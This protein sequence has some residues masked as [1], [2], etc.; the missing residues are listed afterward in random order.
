MYGDVF[1]GGTRSRH[2]EIRLQPKDPKFKLSYEQIVGLLA[3]AGHSVKAVVEPGDPRSKSGKFKTYITT[4]GFSV[5]FAGGGNAGQTRENTLVG[6]LL[7]LIEG[8]TPSPHLLDLLDKLG[9]EPSNVVSADLASAKRVK[10]PLALNPS[11]VGEIISD[12]TIGLL[13]GSRVFISLKVDTGGG[14]SLSNVG[15]TGAF[16]LN[17]SSGTVTQAKHQYDSLLAAVGLSKQKIAKGLQSIVRGDPMKDVV[18]DAPRFDLKTLRGFL[19]SAYGYGYWYVKE[20]KSGWEVVD[21]TTYDKLVE[22]VGDPLVEKVVYPGISVTRPT[23]ASSRSRAVVS[24]SKGH[25]YEF[26]V[27]NTEGTGLIPTKILVD[28]K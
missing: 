10:R 23:A 13:D 3:S 21:L 26:V 4:T 12:V 20:S 27:R 28:V 15:Y 19:S 11:D 9:V 6:E 2:G 22:H 14:L 8:Q 25:R 17:T 7:A 5:V 24:T 16:A 18:D 1:K